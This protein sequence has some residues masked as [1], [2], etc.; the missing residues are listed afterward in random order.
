M[1][2][3]PSIRMASHK[4]EMPSTAVGDG[5]DLATYGPGMNIGRWD[6]D[7]LFKG[8]FGLISRFPRPGGV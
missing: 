3:I 7:F 5:A 4:Q 8:P 6:F 1:F 2:A